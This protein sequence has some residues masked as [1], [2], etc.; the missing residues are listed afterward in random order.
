MELNNRASARIG[1]RIFKVRREKGER[2]SNDDRV[3]RAEEHKIL[4]QERER[5]GNDGMKILKEP[6]MSVS[7]SRVL[8]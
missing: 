4:S 3:C 7:E 5:G 2:D 6:T 8:A 1:F